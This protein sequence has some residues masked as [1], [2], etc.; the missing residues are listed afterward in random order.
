MGVSVPRALDDRIRH[1]LAAAGVTEPV[2]ITD[3]P[4]SG[5]NQIVEVTGANR[6]WIAKRTAAP[7][8]SWFATRVAPTVG[9]VPPCVPIEDPDLVIAERLTDTP[10]VHELADRDPLA[11]LEALVALAEPLAEL[12]AWPTDDDMPPCAAALPEL[13]PVHIGAL[14]DATEPA[15]ELLRRLHRRD[16]LRDAMRRT[17]VVEE[18]T[19]L[20]H[21][22]LKADNV[23]VTPDTPTI[24]DWELC[25]SGPLAWDLGSVV[26]SMLA[27]WVDS[28]DLDRPDAAAWLAGAAVP[29]ERVAAAARSFVGTYRRAARRRVPGPAAITAAAATWLVARA[30]A[31]SLQRLTVDPRLLLRLVV[32]EGA[33]RDPG[34]LLGGPVLAESVGC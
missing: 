6:A 14:V 27:M 1:A 15:R 12:H 16:A 28:A 26:G 20:I 24:I 3:H 9:W 13:D 19:G 11:A 22:D 7:A 30:W 8:E 10:T 23:L 29:Y 5:R 32:A 2:T 17:Y 31:E 21:G 18:P 33:V 4:R 25:G 34:R